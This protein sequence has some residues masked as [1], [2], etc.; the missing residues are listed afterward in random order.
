MILSSANRFIFISGIPLYIMKKRK[1]KCEA[2]VSSSSSLGKEYV[3]TATF[4]VS[5]AQTLQK[6]S[7]HSLE[8][9]QWHFCVLKS[10]RTTREHHLELMKT[11]ASPLSMLHLAQGSPNNLISKLQGTTLMLCNPTCAC[12]SPATWQGAWL[13]ISRRKPPETRLDFPTCKTRKLAAFPPSP[14]NSPH[15]DARLGHCCDEGPHLRHRERTCS[16]PIR[17]SNTLSQLRR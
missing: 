13:R 17:H 8:D 11:T 7:F 1:D 3:G 5:P 14:F 12:C 6:A 15:K 16:G 2:S 10:L 9:H 4:R